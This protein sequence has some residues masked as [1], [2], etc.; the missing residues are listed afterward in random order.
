MWIR[1]FSAPL[2]FKSCTD[3][4]KL[5]AVASDEADK[6]FQLNSL[7]V[8]IS[9]TVSSFLLHFRLVCKTAWKEKMFRSLSFLSCRSAQGKEIAIS[10]LIHTVF[11][12][13]SCHRQSP[14]FSPCSLKDVLPQTPIATAPWRTIHRVLLRENEIKARKEHEYSE[15]RQTLCSLSMWFQIPYDFLLAPKWQRNGIKTLSTCCL[16]VFF[17]FRN[18]F[19]DLLNY[20]LSHTKDEWKRY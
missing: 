15:S 4:H 6:L 8:K 16:F 13:H 9:I 19:T 5:L 14:V 18:N 7:L 10:F 12:K 11:H 3:N 1:I 17:H 2:A 20:L